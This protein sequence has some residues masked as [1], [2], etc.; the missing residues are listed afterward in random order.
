MLGDG[1]VLRIGHRRRLACRAE[2]EDAVG[3]A[4]ELIVDQT[5]ERREVDLAVV[6]E[7]SDQGHDRSG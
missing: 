3:A 2:H 5:V 6:L 4:L 7:R 1:Y